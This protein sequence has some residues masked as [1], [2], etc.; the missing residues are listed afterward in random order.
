VRARSAATIAVL[1]IVQGV[2]DLIAGLALCGLGAYVGSGGT[3]LP[4]AAFPVE[5][6]VAVV[7]FGPLLIAAAALKIVAG[8]RNYHYRA[9]PLGL[10][11]LASCLVS[12]LVCYCAPLSLALMAWGLVLYRRPEVERAF[13]MGRQGLSREWIEA[14][15][16]R[17]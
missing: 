16:A 13:L 7:V 12:A 15:L 5:S 3:G 8:L 17:P 2:H 14:T 1:L 11:A 6:Q 4:V 9:L 10:L